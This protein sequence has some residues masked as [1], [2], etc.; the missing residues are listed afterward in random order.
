VAA[1]ALQQIYRQKRGNNQEPPEKRVRTAELL[2]ESL[3]RAVDTQTQQIQEQ[4]R[5]IEELTAAR[6]TLE[7]QLV[8]VST[9]WSEKRSGLQQEVSNL[10]AIADKHCQQLSEMLDAQ[11]IE[12]TTRDATLFDKKQTLSEQRKAAVRDRTMY[13]RQLSQVQAEA[14]TKQA[15]LHQQITDAESILLE[16]LKSADKPPE[17]PSESDKLRDMIDTKSA[18]IRQA[19]F[20]I[21]QLNGFITTLGTEM[22]AISDERDELDEEFQRLQTENESLKRRI[23]EAK[24]KAAH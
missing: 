16:T 6:R 24:S 1:G 17:R 12:G 15:Q 18:Q 13:E 8:E 23:E 11:T 9:V 5:K 19:H 14:E 3:K 21:Q 10:K 22:R 2:H 7:Q 20:V 4:Q